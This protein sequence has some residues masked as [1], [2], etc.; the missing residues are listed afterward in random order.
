MRCCL[1]EIVEVVAE[2]VRTEPFE[3]ARVAA[4]ARLMDRRKTAE[5]LVRVA[6][7]VLLV[8][9]VGIAKARG[10]SMWVGARPKA[11]LHPFLVPL[12]R[13]M[14]ERDVELDLELRVVRATA[15]REPEKW[16]VPGVVG[17]G[18]SEFVVCGE[19]DAE[20]REAREEVRL[21][22]I[23]EVGERDALGVRAPVEK[24]V[25]EIPMACPQGEIERGVSLEIRIIAVA[26]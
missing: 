19:I 18:L 10:R 9:V 20:G 14:D 7:A 1:V 3:D 16:L 13:V 6:L 4:A 25:E 22:R 8:R 15:L 12:A 2:G 17:E 11:E 5:P 24:E 23:E 21:I 26:E